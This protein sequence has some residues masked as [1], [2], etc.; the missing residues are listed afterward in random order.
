MMTAPASFQLNP[1][2]EGS[3]PPPKPP[4][5]QKEQIYK[6]LTFFDDVDEHA[7]SV[8]ISFILSQSFILFCG[9][10]PFVILSFHGL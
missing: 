1:V 8:C 3:N 9:N 4:Q 6:D 2:P 10:S 7:I 5:L